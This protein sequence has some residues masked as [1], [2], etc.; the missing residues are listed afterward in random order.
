MRITAQLIDAADRQTRL[1]RDLR[2]QARRRVRDPGRDRRRRGQAAEGQDPR[3][4]SE[5]APDRSRGLLALPSGHAA[6]TEANRRGAS[7]RPSPPAPGARDRSPVR[8]GLGAA[9]GNRSQRGHHRRAVEGS[10]VPRGPR[11]GLRRR[12]R[13]I[14]NTR[15]PM[16]ASAAWP[17]SRTTSPPPRGTSSGRSRSIPR[18]W[19]CS[20]T[21]PRCSRGSAG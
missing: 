1:V 6:H 10:G 16:P 4:G 17:S 3:P 9:G 7:R 15:G 13:S 19:S 12:S 21:A 18:I 8:A 11:G 2:P 20:E 14:R 5:G